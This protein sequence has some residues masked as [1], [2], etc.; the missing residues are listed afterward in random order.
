[1]SGLVTRAA[2][3][4]A[5]MQ[6]K[7]LT[8]VS[9]D[10]ADPLVGR[11]YAQVEEDFGLLAPPVS[12]HAPAPALLAA[13]WVM[14]RETLVAGGHADRTAK[15][16][17]AAAV[18]LGNGCPYCVD[19]HGS[20]LY[21][22]TSADDATAVAEGRLDEVG[23][24]RLRAI[25][26]WAWAAGRPSTSPAPFPSGQLP[27]FAGVAVVFHYLNRIVNVF[28]TAS[29][30][31]DQVPAGV[32]PRLRR[33]AGRM[34]RPAAQRFCEP[35]ASLDLL[36]EA[37]LPGDL[38]WAAGT[39]HVADGLA[40][41]AAAIEAAGETAVPGAVRELTLARLAAWDGEPPGLSS[42]WAD[43]AVAGLLEGERAAGRLALLT[44]MASYQV[45]GSVVEEFRRDR[46]DDAALIGLTSWAA[47]AAAREVGSRLRPERDVTNTGER[48][49]Q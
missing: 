10:G 3:R 43:E 42:G 34:V 48:T 37:P 44:A 22:L 35:G 32:R 26:G 36:P 28:L 27:E 9:P 17:V 40:R 4:G 20:T 46:P 8:P 12:L 25:A 33:L 14:L 16:V 47:M 38:S 41:S 7:H 18:S 30:F 45:G 39:R 5:R 23:D 31:P 11:V 1:M 15:E 24:A 29:P 49:E 21:G 13:S 19:V 2:R 6:I